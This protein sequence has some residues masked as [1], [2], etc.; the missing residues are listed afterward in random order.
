MTAASALRHLRQLAAIKGVDADPVA[1]PRMAYVRLGGRR[2]RYLDWPGDGEPI[3]FLHG[4]AQTAHTWDVCCLAMGD[5][6]RRIA[7]EQRGHGE[8]DWCAV[9]DYSIG[10]HCAD[11]ER[12]VDHLGVARIAVAGMSMGGINA[13]AWAARNPA[14]ASALIVVDVAPDIQYA[15]A[16][17]AVDAAGSAQGTFRSLD[18]ALGRALAFRSDR[19]PELLRAALSRNLRRLAPDEWS[20]KYDRRI[21]ADTGV[22]AILAERRPL[23]E[24]VGAITCPTLVVRGDRSDVLHAADAARLTKALPRAREVLIARA[25]HSVQ[26]DNPKDLA[27]AIVGFLDAA[28][29]PAGRDA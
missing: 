9:D 20:W 14:R 26:S 18:E 23:W 5:R 28:I 8:S 2:F 24:E 19:D 10:A 3:L 12:F 7:L 11:I 4:G 6:Y 17:R 16:K 13:L 21:F 1:L 29:D 22:D 27:A 15:G 25:G